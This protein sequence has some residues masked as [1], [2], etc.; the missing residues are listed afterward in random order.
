MANKKTF[1][2]NRT[3]VA[4]KHLKAIAA[5]VRKINLD[6]ETLMREN[7]GVAASSPDWDALT[8]SIVIEFLMYVVYVLAIKDAGAVEAA[9][10]APIEEII[11]RIALTA[12]ASAPFLSPRPTQRPAAMAGL[13]AKSD[14]LQ[15]RRGRHHQLR[16]NQTGRDQ[17]PGDPA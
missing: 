17:G 12:T 7:G 9:S 3:V 2:M 5:R 10:A 8:A 1:L 11:T 15:A 4:L 16:P 13:C 6:F 14:P